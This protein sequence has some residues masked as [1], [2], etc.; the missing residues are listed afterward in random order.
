MEVEVRCMCCDRLL[1]VEEWP[2]NEQTR[3]QSTS[4]VCPACLGH[5]NKTGRWPEK[6]KEAA[7]GTE[8]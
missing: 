5:F 3:G 7:H 1:R 2:E 8:R 6:R 4:G